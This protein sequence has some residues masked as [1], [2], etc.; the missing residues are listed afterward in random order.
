MNIQITRAH[1]LKELDLAY[2]CHHDWFAEAG[3]ITPNSTRRYTDNFTSRSVYFLAMANQQAVGLVRAVERAPFR[4]LADFEIDPKYHAYDFSE[5]NCMEA[6]ELCWRSHCGVPVL[7]HLYRALFQYGFSR[8][9]RT[10]ICNLDERVV[11][12]TQRMGLPFTVIGKTRDYMGS[13]RTPIMMDYE[14]LKLLF[15]QHRC[16]PIIHL[17]QTPLQ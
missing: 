15:D 7:P 3:Y 10:M 17:L 2:Q 16:N 4:T 5:K 11:R 8:Q 1:S 12:I 9:K 6:S 13:A 14:H